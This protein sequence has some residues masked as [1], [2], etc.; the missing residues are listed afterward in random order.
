VDVVLPDYD[1]ILGAA[2]LGVGEEPTAAE[3]LVTEWPATQ[4]RLR[5]CAAPSVPG[6]GLSIR[7]SFAAV[8]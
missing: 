8:Q 7:D 1:L 3:R 2:L 6:R 5:T 4:V